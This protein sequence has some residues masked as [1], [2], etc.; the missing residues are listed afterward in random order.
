MANSVPSLT[1]FITGTSSGFGHELVRAALKRGDFVVATSRRPEKV[2]AAFPEAG[3]RLL[4]LGL[5]LRDPAAVDAAAAQALSR[6][7]RI[8][9][10]VNNAGYGLMGAVEEASEAELSDVFE[11]NVFALLR[12][13]RALLP[14]MR[15]RK[16]GHIVNFSSIAGLTTAPGW[17]LYG[18]TKFAVE[19]LS[20]AL[21]QEVGPLGIK[22]SLIEPGPFRTGFLDGSLVFADKS[23]ADYKDTAGKTRAYRDEFAGAQKGDPAK[24]IEAIINLVTTP[25]P[26]LHLL[27]G[28]NAFARAHKKVDALLQDFEAWREVTLSAD[29]PD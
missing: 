15:A 19:G 22:V 21:A 23:I 27:L 6:M 26:P 12:V 9:V 20:E 4:S 11:I 25:N 7:G 17:G 1:W 2:S 16:K 28:A 5:D 3:D 10:L 29:F 24:A 13:T 14:S 8:D 18:A